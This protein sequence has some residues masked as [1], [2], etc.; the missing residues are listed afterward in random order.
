MSESGY[1]SKDSSKF[2]VR[3]LFHHI[4]ALLWVPWIISAIFVLVEENA[5]GRIYTAVTAAIYTFVAFFWVL[6]D[7]VSFKYPIGWLWIPFEILTLLLLGASVLGSLM[8]G[9]YADPG[10]AT[11]TV[12]KPNAFDN[13]FLI[14]NFALYLAIGVS[15]IC[16]VIIMFYIGSMAW[17]LQGPNPLVAHQHNSTYIPGKFSLCRRYFMLGYSQHWRDIKEDYQEFT[18][19]RTPFRRRV[20]EHQSLAL[21]RGSLAIY[22]TIALALYF[23]E[24]A[25]HTYESG[26][27]ITISTFPKAPVKDLSNITVVATQLQSSGASSDLWGLMGTL[28]NGLNVSISSDDGTDLGACQPWDPS[29]SSSFLANNLTLLNCNLNPYQGNDYNIS[30]QVAQMNISYASYPS[31]TNATEIYS[32]LAIWLISSPTMEKVENR[33]HE[34]QKQISTRSA[35]KLPPDSKSLAF[36]SLGVLEYGSERWPTYTIENPTSTT[37]SKG[38]SSLILRLDK[39]QML[40]IK[41]KF[42]R[43]LVLDAFQAIGSLGGV[44]T[45]VSGIFGTVFGRDLLAILT[46]GQSLSPFG[47]IVLLPCV[48]RFYK[49]KINKEFFPNLQ[50]ELKEK[51][52]AAF[53]NEVAIDINFILDSDKELTSPNQSTDIAKYHHERVENRYESVPLYY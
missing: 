7:S 41:Y 19:H 40:F 27:E 12:L 5:H 9:P 46:G 30:R 10:Y 1:K 25:Y 2:Y 33:I 17:K 48:R 3:I 43:G 26:V 24:L 34:V 28:P 31:H 42:Q 35:F 8:Y 13:A 32:S 4:L 15:C 22:A 53:M 44:L 47:L 51:G 39:S 21:I 50:N 11:D 18:D 49:K 23:V 20:Y 16:L 38:K 6:M 29:L 37:S 14:F 52:M 36:V 45:I